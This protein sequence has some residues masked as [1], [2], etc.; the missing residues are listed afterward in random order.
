MNITVIT[1]LAVAL[2]TAAGVWFF[3][4]AR[5]ESTIADVRLEQSNER[6][7]AVAQ[8]RTTERAIAKTYQEALNAARTREA[9]FRTEL[10]NLHAASDSLRTQLS[11][12]ARLV[13][14][15]PP[16]TVA[17]YATTVSELLADCSR[18]RAYYAGKATGHANDVRAH[19]EAWPVIE[20]QHNGSD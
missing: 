14:A 8:T 6:L 17:E 5:M 12:A 1:H 9:L 16:A 10:D 15:A 7:T 18:E 11:H 13:A 2:V 4:D 19:R 20:G 3:Q